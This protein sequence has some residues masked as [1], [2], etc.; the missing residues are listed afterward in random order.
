MAA[1]FVGG[2]LTAFS[3]CVSCFAQFES[4]ITTGPI[5]R[6]EGGG[7]INEETVRTARETVSHSYLL[8]N[9]TNQTG[10]EKNVFTFSRVIFKSDLNRPG[11]NGFD[12]GRGGGGRLGWVIDY[13]DADLN[14]S[15]RL[16][17]MTSMKVDPDGRALK[18]TNPDLWTL[19]F[20]YMEHVERMALSADE[21]RNLRKYLQLGGA[22]FVSDF[23]G[24]IAW[25]NFSTEMARVL[26][27]HRW[28]D[29]TTDHPI[30][31]CLFD[32]RR[33]FNYLQIPTMQFWNRDYN[34]TDISFGPMWLRYRGEGSEEMHVRALLDKKDR[35]MVLAIMNSDVSDGWEREG[36]NTTY[37]KE[38]SETRAYP[39][40]INLLFYLMTH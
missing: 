30:F 9:W 10:F 6:L 14:L 32:L 27:E 8:P 1:R 4:P 36:E 39:L 40:A 15:Y 11:S 2:G 37:F 3:L 18:L 12:G 26:P 23:W 17:Q 13:P 5:V 21:V 38:F 28:V 16:Q 22:I 35:I 29:L 34:P 25:Q 31:H 19:P 33:S 20:L 24:I 7:Y